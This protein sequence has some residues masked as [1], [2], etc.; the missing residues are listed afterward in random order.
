MGDEKFWLR[1]Q[2]EELSPDWVVTQNY[3]DCEQ[4]GSSDRLQM[5]GS[6][7]GLHSNGQMNVIGLLMFAGL[8]IFALP[9]LPILADKYEAAPYSIP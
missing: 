5:V 2:N 1:A 6:Y 9:L 7:A 4:G 3:T 8:V